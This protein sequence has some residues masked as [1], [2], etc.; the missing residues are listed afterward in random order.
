M[1]RRDGGNQNEKKLGEQASSN[2]GPVKEARLV[3]AKKSNSK[4]R[5]HAEREC[6]PEERTRGRK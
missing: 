6:R 4:L 2:L 5:T 3:R 1:R